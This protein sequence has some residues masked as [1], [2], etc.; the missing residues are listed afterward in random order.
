MSFPELSFLKKDDPGREDGH[1]ISLGSFAGELKRGSEKTGSLAAFSLAFNDDALI[2]AGLDPTAEELTRL[3]AAML[4]HKYLREAEGV[5]DLSDISKAAELADLYDCRRCVNHIAQGYLRG[6][7]APVIYPLPDGRSLR[8][9]DARR[10]VTEEEAGDIL[11]AL[12]KL[13]AAVHSG[14]FN[15]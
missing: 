2:A 4:I 5:E 7:I 12:K 10:P 13:I 11:T 6:L 1:P 14:S 9:F 15:N 8:V 3:D